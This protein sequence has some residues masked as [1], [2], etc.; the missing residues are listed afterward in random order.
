MTMTARHRHVLASAGVGIL[1]SLVLGGWL[2]P[3]LGVATG[4]IAH[5]WLAGQPSEPTLPNGDRR[6]ST[7]RSR[8]TCWPRPSEPAHR[9]RWRSSAS[10]TPLTGPMVTAPAPGGQGTAAA[11]PR[12]TKRGPISASTDASGSGSPFGRTEPEQ[13]S[14]PRGPRCNGWP[15]ICGRDLLGAVD[16]AA[17]RAGV[18]I[19]LPLGLCFLPA[20]VLAGLVPV[21]VAVLGDVLSG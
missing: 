11:A 18:L 14:R 7:C 19:V 13:W 17:R 10:P 3:V 2:G 21:L 5:R 1:I 9:R 4:L 6:G 8:S 20:F 15:T 16:A 12:P